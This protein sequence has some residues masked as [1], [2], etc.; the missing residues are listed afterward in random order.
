MIYFK[1]F[2]K[3]LDKYRSFYATLNLAIVL[4]CFDSIFKKKITYYLSTLP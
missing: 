3:Y 1:I 4:F 2:L